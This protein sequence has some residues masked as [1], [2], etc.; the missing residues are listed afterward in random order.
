ME[1]I[2]K[3]GRSSKPPRMMRWWNPKTKDIRR[4]LYMSEMVRESTQGRE[5]FVPST[6][7]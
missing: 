4:A 6:F 1:A 2:E 3:K 7:S 5:E